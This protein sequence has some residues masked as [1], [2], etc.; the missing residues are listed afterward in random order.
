MGSLDPSGLEAGRLFYG[1]DYNP[2]QWP[3]DV[4]D[5]D[6]RLM[7][8]AGVNLVTVGAFCW[9]DLEPA[10]RS[11]DFGWL[12]EVLDLLADAGIGVDLATPTAAPPP[13]LT[14]R[15]PDVLPVD[16]SG[17]RYSHGSRQHFCVC[18][19]DYRRLAL[20][21]VERLATEV[22]RHEALRMWHVHNEYACHVAYCYCEHHALA[23]RSWLENRYGSVKALNDAWGTAF[24]SQR[25][26]DFSEVL[27]PRMTPA[28]HNPGQ[29]LDYKRFTSE[30]FL[31]EFLQ[32]KRVLK[33]A[34]PGVPV[35]TNFMGFFKPLDYF[36][37]ARDSMW[38]R[39]TTTL[40]Q[41]TPRARHCLQCTMT[42]SAA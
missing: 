4:W 38:S 39:P 11:F 20:R 8:E 23:F 26:Q 17:A 36:A 24:W 22:G 30:V 5:E 19:P 9:A 13:W 21:M 29:V 7:R 18:S 3:R 31:E 2:E 40:T 42:W 33:A 35:T 15:Y 37:W 12:Q 34:T 25:Y 10:D 6:V 41:P 27:P 14:T 32:E 28:S 16:A 1:G